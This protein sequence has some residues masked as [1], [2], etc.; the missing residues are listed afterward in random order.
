MTAS[1]SW[2]GVVHCRLDDE[3]ISTSSLVIL[4]YVFYFLF[5]RWVYCPQ[6]SSKIGYS[7][8]LKV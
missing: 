7:D 6:R 5:Q 2:P 3:V 4:T 1:G 8:G